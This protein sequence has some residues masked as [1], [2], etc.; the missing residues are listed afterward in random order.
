M[1]HTVTFRIEL[2]SQ[3]KKTIA[4]HQ[5]KLQKWFILNLLD[6]LRKFN[7]TRESYLLAL[8]FI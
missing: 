6:K 7:V 5:S 1:K 2:P 8:P 3:S 4:L